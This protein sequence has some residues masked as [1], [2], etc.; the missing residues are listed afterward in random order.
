MSRYEMSEVTLEMVKEFKRTYATVE[1]CT[2]TGAELLVVF[3]TSDVR[4]HTAGAAQ[5]G[6][7]EGGWYYDETALKEFSKFLK[8]I[9]KA[10]KE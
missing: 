1:V 8:I 2:A 7:N 10:Y 4:I 5:I 6:G 3:C 9:R